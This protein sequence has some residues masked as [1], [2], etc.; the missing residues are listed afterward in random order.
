MELSLRREG[1]LG[2]KVS[3]GNRGGQS[4]VGVRGTLRDGP[5]GMHGRGFFGVLWTVLGRVSPGILGV[6]VGHVLRGILR[7]ILGGRH[8]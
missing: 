8:T 7:A 3:L 6:W 2:R 5:G 4:L 1:V